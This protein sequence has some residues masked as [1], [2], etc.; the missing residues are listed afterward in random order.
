MHRSPFPPTC[1]VTLTRVSFHRG[2]FLC[3]CPAS[4]VCLSVCLSECH[5]HTVKPLVIGSNVRGQCRVPTPNLFKMFET[6]M[7][8]SGS[9][10]AKACRP[11]PASHLY[12]YIKKLGE[13]SHRH[14]ATRGL[15]LL[16]QQQAG[17]WVFPTGL[18][19]PGLKQSIFPNVL[20]V[21]GEKKGLFFQF[22][23][24]EFYIHSPMQSVNNVPSPLSWLI[25]VCSISEITE[26]DV[27]IFATAVMDL[28]NFL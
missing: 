27:W 2:L 25:F 3:L 28:S 12:L 7:A 15:W 18:Q 26:R 6:F 5:Y 10:Q 22:W 19:T 11:N 23:G 13:D 20:Y 1:S 16:S 17:I 24:P 21:L 8:W 9:W 4:L 14:V